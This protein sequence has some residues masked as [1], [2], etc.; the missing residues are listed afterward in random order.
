MTNERNETIAAV[1]TGTGGAV[2]G[3]RVSGERAVP[4][5]GARGGE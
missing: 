4:R 2:A 5:G 3:S 1:A